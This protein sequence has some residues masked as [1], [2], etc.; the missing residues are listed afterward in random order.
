MAPGTA[1]GG[2]VRLVAAG[3]AVRRRRSPSTASTWTSHAGEFFSLLGPSGCGK[4]TTLRMIAGFERPTSGE[5]LL[6][7][8]D[9]V[10]VPAAPAAGEHRLPVLRAVPVPGRARQRRVRPALP[11]GRQG[12]RPGAGSTRRSS[13]SQ[14]SAYAASPARPA[15]RRP[16]A[17]GGAGPGAGARPAGAAARRA[18]GRPGRQAAQAP[19]GRAQGHPAGGR[20][21]VRLRHPRPG[22]GAH[23]VRP[24][25]G[26]ARRPGRAG[27]AH[28]R[29]S[30]R[31]RARRT[32]PASSGR[33]TCWTSRC[34]T[35]PT[36]APATCRL[37]ALPL[38]AVGAARAVPAR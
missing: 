7:G 4:T 1:R 20:H 37:G 3:Q 17:A 27:R 11:E 21:H 9:L 26:D 35:H 12:R 8:A 2:A 29:R 30:T 15:V 6:D 28:R 13:W 19:A 22:G 34:S 24:A 36:A 14:M 33:P 16:A 5:I 18:A 10:P 32:S 23:D 31:S 38:R 25:R